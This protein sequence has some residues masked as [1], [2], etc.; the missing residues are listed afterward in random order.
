MWP[1]TSTDASAS[2]EP[3]D[4][5]L[6]GRT[7]GSG[8]AINARLIRRTRQ[9]AV[10]LRAFRIGLAKAMEQDSRRAASRFVSSHAIEQPFGEVNIGEGR[11]LHH[12]LDR[13]IAVG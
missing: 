12:V 13:A 1:D 2:R 10:S 6:V 4:Q 5:G 7:G 11:F 3:D 9:S 8:S